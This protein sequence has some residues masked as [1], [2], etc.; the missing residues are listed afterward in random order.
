MCMGLAIPARK[1]A[2]RDAPA[3]FDPAHSAA[4]GILR[5]IPGSTRWRVCPMRHQLMAPRSYHEASCNVPRPK[6][7]SMLIR[8]S[9]STRVPQISSSHGGCSLSSPQEQPAHGISTACPTCVILVGF[10]FIPRPVAGLCPLHRQQS[11]FFTSALSEKSP[12]L[13][14]QCIKDLLCRLAYLAQ[15]QADNIQYRS[16]VPASFCLLKFAHR[17]SFQVPL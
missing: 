6:Y 3:L 10:K 11:L 12:G 17:P 4:S 15:R 14:R 2:L 5:R 7:R 9:P 13:F 16:R 1:P 8:G